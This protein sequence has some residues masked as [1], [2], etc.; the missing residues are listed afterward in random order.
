MNAETIIANILTGSCTP[1]HDLVELIED[2]KISYADAWNAYVYRR[3][4]PM[5][6][7]LYSFAQSE[8][9]FMKRFDI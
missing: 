8:R 3:K 9:D 1:A 7:N 2:G 6:S 4:V 5:A